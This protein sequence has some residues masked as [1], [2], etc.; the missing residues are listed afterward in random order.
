MSQGSWLFYCDS[1]SAQSDGEDLMEDLKH[2]F[3][4]VSLNKTQ[5]LG[6]PSLKKKKN[7]MTFVILG[8]GGGSKIFKMSSF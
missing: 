2:I 8:G 1:N 6:K 3:L 5:R 7:K 4:L